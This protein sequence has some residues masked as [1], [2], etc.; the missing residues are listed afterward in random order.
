MSHARSPHYFYDLY[1]LGDLGF[2]KLTKN[3]IR[4][5]LPGP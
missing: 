3:L 2:A 4:V 5:L 1:H